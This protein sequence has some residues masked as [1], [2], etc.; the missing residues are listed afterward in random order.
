MTN[1]VN[2][3]S[4]LL[5]IN[6]VNFITGLPSFLQKSNHMGSRVAFSFLRVLLLWLSLFAF[7]W[8]L[9]KWLL[10]ASSAMYLLEMFAC[11]CRKRDT[12][13]E[14]VKLC[15]IAS[16]V[17]LINFIFDRPSSF[18]G[19]MFSPVVA[20]ANIIAILFSVC[21]LIYAYEFSAAWG[22]YGPNPRLKDLDGGYCSTYQGK[23]ADTS[24]F[25]SKHCTDALSS[26]PPNTHALALCHGAQPINLTSYFHAIAALL[27]ISFGL[28]VGTIPS[29]V[30]RLVTTFED[31]Q[32][33]KGK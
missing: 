15:Y 30:A 21:Y 28:Y 13:A 3:L 5:Y 4:N 22:C 29:K 20:A 2:G 27:S 9:G 16:H 10:V 17:S 14:N 7:P 24:G 19:S 6:E 26:N 8:K 12:D 32:Q 18:V 1:T 33:K 31:E 11:Y 25:G 23:G